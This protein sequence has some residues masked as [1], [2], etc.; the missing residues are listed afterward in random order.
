LLTS[1]KAAARRL[2]NF[3]TYYQ[4]KERAG[5]VGRAGVA[6]VLTQVKTG[7]PKLRVHMVGHSFGGRLVTAAA[8]SGRFAVDSLSLLQAAFSHYGFAQRWDG[9]ADGLFRPMV[10]GGYVSGPVIITHTRNDSAVGH[11]YPIASQ[12]ARQTAAWL[13][14]KNDKYGGIGSNGAQKTPEAAGARLLAVGGG[15]DLRPGRLHNLLADNFI[16]DHSDVTGREVAYAVL[17][18][19]RSSGA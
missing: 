13:G 8:S 9:T 17:T 3:G 5:V 18:A 12:I 15:Y 2:V 7:H 14:D 10:T 1:A 4:M 6:D 11:A 19:V 16:H